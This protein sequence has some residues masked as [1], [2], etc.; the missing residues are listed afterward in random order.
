[1]WGEDIGPS[2]EGAT[3]EVVFEI[4]LVTSVLVTQWLVLRRRFTLGRRL[5]WGIVLA[6]VVGLNLGLTVFFAITGD[7][8]G[9]AAWIVTAAVAG[10][11]GGM[12]TRMTLALLARGSATHHELISKN[13]GRQ[14]TNTHLPRI[15]GCQRW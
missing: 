15:T 8:G 14:G 5:Q 1:M 4:V 3:V 9:F 7:P 12:L 10:F 11:V 2:V 6:V 13:V